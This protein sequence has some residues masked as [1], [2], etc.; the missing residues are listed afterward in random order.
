V[1]FRKSYRLA[2]TAVKQQRAEH[3][4]GDREGV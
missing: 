4:V 3:A 1:H 2:R